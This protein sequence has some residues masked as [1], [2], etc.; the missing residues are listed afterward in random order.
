MKLKDFQHI[1]RGLY[2]PI[3]FNTDTFIPL[4]IFSFTQTEGGDPKIICQTNE[5]CAND[6]FQFQCKSRL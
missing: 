6:P 3:N 2:M 5:C 4:P 1:P